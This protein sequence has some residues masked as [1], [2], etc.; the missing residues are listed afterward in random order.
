[1]MVKIIARNMGRD[2]INP[3]VQKL[4]CGLTADDWFALWN[5]VA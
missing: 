2:G 1:M 3:N 4:L 5:D